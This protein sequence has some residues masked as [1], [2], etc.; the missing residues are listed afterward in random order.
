[1]RKYNIKY[2]F[3]Q[4]PV[5]IVFSIIGMIASGAMAILGIVSGIRANI[6]WFF[7]GFGIL[8]VL[9]TI[10]CLVFFLVNT[11]RVI[12]YDEMIIV[13]R[14]FGQVIT[15]C[16]ISEIKEVYYKKCKKAR[17]YEGNYYVIRDNRHLDNPNDYRQKGAYIKFDHTKV[18][19]NI[20]KSFWRGEIQEIEVGQEIPPFGEEIKPWMQK[21]SWED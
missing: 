19:E 7:I 6:D 5:N 9:L 12:I 11:R 21:Q 16:K 20:V 14:L 4:A 3:F 1:L 17:R 8:S 2:S 13:R 15:E 18:R 10:G